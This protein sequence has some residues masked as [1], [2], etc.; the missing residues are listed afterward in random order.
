MSSEI[1]RRAKVAGRMGRV[2]INDV[3]CDY[4]NLAVVCELILVLLTFLKLL[5]LYILFAEVLIC[6]DSELSVNENVFKT[7]LLEPER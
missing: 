6:K 7:V 5:L 2:N 1:C 3:I 4:L